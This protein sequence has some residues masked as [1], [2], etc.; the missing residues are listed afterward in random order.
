MI[1]MGYSID[2]KIDSDTSVLLTERTRSIDISEITEISIWDFSDLKSEINIPSAELEKWYN[3]YLYKNAYYYLK[4]RDTIS[5]ILNELLGEYISR[6]MELPTISYDLVADKTNN[7][8]VGLLSKNFR[9]KD[10]R[11]KPSYK[12]NIF[13]NIYFNG[14]LFSMISHSK[15]HKTL[16]R[17][18]VKDFYT[19]LKDR[20][21]NVICEKKLFGLNLGVSYDYEISFDKED[22][23]APYYSPLFKN[24]FDYNYPIPIT[25]DTICAMLEYNKYL[26]EQ[27]DK[28]LEFDMVRALDNIRDAYKIF[29]PSEI[30]EYYLEFNKERKEHLKDKISK[31]L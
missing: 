8:V 16:C 9:R 17:L 25:I 13:D 1:I 12:L 24:I 29:I 20:D 18:I 27:L 7:K 31:R 15:L 30:E 22:F 2:N 6:Y 4:K 5:N 14:C 26:G 3:W 21:I 19:C 11:Y 23:D 28:M 10:K